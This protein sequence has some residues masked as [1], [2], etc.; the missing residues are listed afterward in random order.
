MELGTSYIL[1]KSLYHRAI[2]MAFNYFLN[3]LG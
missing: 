2:S 3:F 1:G